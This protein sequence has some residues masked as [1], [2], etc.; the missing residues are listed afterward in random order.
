MKTKHIFL[1]AVATL[2][3]AATSCSP[4]APESTVADAESATL[5]NI[6]DREDYVAVEVAVPWNGGTVIG[7]YALVPRGTQPQVPTDSFTVVEVPLERSVVYSMVHTSA[8]D[9]LG[10]ADAVVGVTDAAYFAPDDPMKARLDL[11]LVADVGSSMAPSVEKIISLSPDA[12]LLSPMEGAEPG[13]V[14]GAGIPMIYLPDYLEPNPLARAEW[15]RL[16]GLLYGESAAAD[17]IFAEVKTEYNRLKCLADSC[18][19]R[20]SVITERPYAGVWYMPGG[21]SYKARM[22]ADAGAS[23]AWADE[24]STGSQQLAVEAVVAT[25]AG[26]DYW[27]LNEAGDT[28]AEHLAA[29]MPHAQA[30]AAFPA[31][32]YVCNTLATPMFRDIA[33]HPERVLADMVHIFHP[34]LQSDYKL[35]YYSRLR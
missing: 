35:R 2:M 8:I 32:V 7:R 9:E 14:A 24:P 11:G 28:D 22:L 12:V 17:S 34:E 5:L 31:G 3:L 20:P 25:A 29:D 33:F 13:A 16:I 1:S 21:A 30:F 18:E 23:F 6:D 26:A 19:A 4:T 27:L 15:L 10:R